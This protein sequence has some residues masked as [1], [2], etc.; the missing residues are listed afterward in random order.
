MN[1]RS[2]FIKNHELH[3]ALAAS[4]HRSACRIANEMTSQGMML[5]AGCG[6]DYYGRRIDGTF[7]T[8]HVSLGGFVIMTN[9]Q[10]EDLLLY[11]AAS[12]HDESVVIGLGESD[13]D[14]HPPEEMQEASDG[15]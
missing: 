14:R 7:P 8:T 10:L 5:L 1:E 11:C 9:S 12:I 3:D 4:N 13:L 6:A 2:D 15:L